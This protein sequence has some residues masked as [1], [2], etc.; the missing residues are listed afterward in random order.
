MTSTPDSLAIS[1]PG[2]VLTPLDL[3][4]AVNE[5]YAS[6]TEPD[7]GRERTAQEMHAFWKRLVM[8]GA[9]LREA[10]CSVPF[11]NDGALSKRAKAQA[12]GQCADLAEAHYWMRLSANQI[13]LELPRTETSDAV[14]TYWLGLLDKEL[15]SRTEPPGEGS[16][17]AEE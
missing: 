10:Q 1:P 6:G 13:N 2:K 5:A 11:W 16:S 3:M 12:A 14:A 4:V 15:A 8:G 7:W 17:T 9:R